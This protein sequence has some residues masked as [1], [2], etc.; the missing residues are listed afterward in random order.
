MRAAR[1][2]TI[3]AI[4]KNKDA[5]HKLS[6]FLEI[7]DI[8]LLRVA[9]KEIRSILADPEAA[10]LLF[11][12]A[13]FY[14]FNPTRPDIK[15]LHFW[16][17]L[18]QERAALRTLRIA[19]LACEWSVPISLL[20][21]CD[22]TNLESLTL[23]AKRDFYILDSQMVD[24]LFP[25]E[26]IIDLTV[27]QKAIPQSSPDCNAC[28][29]LMCS[30]YE[31]PPED[32]SLL[33]CLSQRCRGRRLERLDIP[34]LIKLPC[35]IHLLSTFSALKSLELALSHSS[36]RPDESHLKSTQAFFCALFKSVKQ[37]K[38]LKRFAMRSD[39][40]WCDLGAFDLLYKRRGLM[41]LESESLES[42]D[43]ARAGKG[44]CME[45]LHCPSL[46]RLTGVGH[47]MYNPL[48]RR[49]YVRAEGLIRTATGQIVRESEF[50]EEPEVMGSYMI[51]DETQ[52][53]GSV[54][55]RPVFV[56]I[57]LPPGCKM[58]ES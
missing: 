32:F 28:M 50:S 53:D 46:K 41:V 33:T 30:S 1:R 5:T 45:N 19:F 6:T 23:Q 21:R 31:V 40:N 38:A 39:I 25:K 47:Y 11:G 49:R 20:L 26:K 12:Y 56:P 35:E 54:R 58:S 51:E 42:A 27:Q 34:F 36:L 37:L 29:R 48:V 4:L 52:E 55:F 15:A 9:S 16:R 7:K 13:D 8:L 24:A 2:T 22:L 3:L 17:L 10:P 43:L 14:Q 44:F 18:H 57:I